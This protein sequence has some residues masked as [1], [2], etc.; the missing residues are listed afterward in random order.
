MAPAGNG[1]WP[2]YAKGGNLCRKVKAT[3]NI[4]RQG[5]GKNPAASIKKG[6]MY[7]E[8]TRGCR[9]ISGKLNTPQCL[10]IA[11]PDSFDGFEFP[12]DLNA[13]GTQLFVEFGT[14]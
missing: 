5:C 9:A 14:G 6:R 1:H 8:G 7:D 13:V 10:T 11:A 12:V 2:H 4:L 3:P